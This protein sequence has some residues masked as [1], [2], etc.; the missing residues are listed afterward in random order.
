MPNYCNYSMRVVGKQR[1]NVEEFI[2]I[3]NAD[4]NYGTMEFNS[5]RHMFQS[6]RGRK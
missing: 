3:M 5:D 2:K 4:Y 1:K 6:I